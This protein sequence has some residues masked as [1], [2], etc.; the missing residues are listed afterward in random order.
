VGRFGVGFAAVLAVTDEP[1]IG[2]TTTASVRWS[3][4]TTRDEVADI[5]SLANELSHRGGVVPALRLPLPATSLEVPDG[6]DTVVVLPLRDQD[7][8]ALTR[9]LLGSIDAALLL[10]LPVLAEVT[11]EI[12]GV[13]RQL[14][15]SWDADAVTLTDG[16]V[17]TRWL[18]ASSAGLV[19]PDLFVDRPTEE[20]GR[21]AWSVVWALADETSGQPP[22][23]AVVHAPM[24]TDEPLDLPALLVATFPL[25]PSRRHVAPGELRDFVIE[26]AADTYATIVC[27]A[28]DEVAPGLVPRGL[29]AGELDALL[30]RAIVERLK[31]T[32]FLPGDI[33]PSDAV[34]VDPPDAALLEVLTPVLRGLLPAAWSRDRAALDVLGVRR[35]ELSDVVDLLG[36]LDREPAWWRQVYDACAGLATVDRDALG[37]LP[38]PLAD[39]RTVRGVRGA[40]LPT[41]GMDVEIGATLGLRIVHPDA[42][43]PLLERLGA[44]LALPRALLQDPA[45]QAAVAGEGFGDP[46]ATRDAV[47]ALVEAADLAPGEH[48][49]LGQL[50]LVDGLTAADLVLADS[51]LRPLLDE[52]A[53]EVVPDELA[54]RWH[55]STLVATGVLDGFTVLRVADVVLDPAGIDTDVIDLDDVERWVTDVNGTVG[56]ESPLPPVLAELAAVRDLDLIRT[57]AWPAA[58]ALLAADP[59][60]RDAVAAPAHAVRPDGSRVDV[61]PYTTWWLRQ[62]A[63]IDGQPLG[64]LRVSDADAVV[65]ALYDAIRLDMDDELLRALGVRRSLPELLAEPGGP[66]ELL[67]RLADADRLVAR[68]LLRAAYVALAAVDPDRVQPP[69]RLRALVN[70][71][72]MVVPAESAVLADQPDL[73]PLAGQRP[74]LLVP[75]GLAPSLADVLAVPLLSEEIPGRVGSVGVQQNVPREVLDVLP[76]APSTWTEHEDLIVDGVSVEWR[77]IDGVVHASTLSGLA[78]G[79]ALASGQWQQRHLV[80]ELLADPAAASVLHDERDLDDAIYS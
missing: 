54:Q 42:A 43:H 5:A 72:P 49:W 41:P 57:D 22:L 61:L 60:L 17:P 53:L 10:A 77:V 32:P 37:A 27:R 44:A 23:D 25:D 46:E 78:R 7:A 4:S 33:R 47:L 65:G 67:E 30:R 40:Y 63:S 2:S 29:P 76:H 16:G 80:A 15:A 18:V 3:R 52:D 28:P 14:E 1:A 51:P 73:V 35:L 56:S 79:L 58:L 19:E 24:P 34:T 74:L 75:A 26:R 62:H 45:V 13:G 39:G 31:E 66:Q 64:D 12:D 6:Y 11:I 50:G 36:E 38:V 9:Q 21:P 68:D 55:R 8:E 48:S 70:G 20:R 69:E 59:A 71:A